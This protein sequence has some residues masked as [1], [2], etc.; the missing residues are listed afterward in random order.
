[1]TLDE[2]THM[3]IWCDGGMEK[4]PGIG[5]YGLYAKIVDDSASKVIKR[6]KSSGGKLRTTN[7]EMEIFAVL[8]SLH[9][10]LKFPDLKVTIYTDSQWTIKVVTKE[11]KVQKKHA[12]KIL[13]LQQ[14]L[15]NCNHGYEEERVRL[16]WVPGHSGV[17]GNEIA[18]DY[19]T[20][21][22]QRMVRTKKEFGI[23]LHYLKDY[24][25]D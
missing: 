8:A 15:W 20:D 10:A 7:I 25:E 12:H 24:E 21:A 6:F 14:M 19:A 18:D 13:L 2:A 9:Y 11:W 22:V 3:K 23:W 16:K 17:P 4:N 1:M 5:G